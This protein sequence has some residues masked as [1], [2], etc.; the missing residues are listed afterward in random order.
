M[1]NDFSSLNRFMRNPLRIE[2]HLE[3]QI[4]SD[5]LPIINSKPL[6][7][8][9]YILPSQV[10][11]DMSLC[12]CTWNCHLTTGY[13]DVLQMIEISSSKFDIMGI[14]E[15]FLSSDQSLSAFSFPGYD[16][17]VR[18]R[19]TMNRGGLG[20]LIKKNMKYMVREDLGV[21]IEGKIESFCLELEIEKRKVL[22]SVVYR[23]PSARLDEFVAGF[24][25][26]TR[27]V[28][29]TSMDF[30]CMGDF[31][32]NLLDL[33][34]DNLDFF[35]YM[36]SSDLYPLTCVP[37]R[38]STH[39]ATLIDNVFVGPSYLSQSYSDVIVYPGSDHLPVIAHVTCLRKRRIPAKKILTRELKKQNLNSFAEELS[40]IK[41]DSVL[42]ISGDSSLAYNQFMYIFQP[43]YEKTCPLRL[44]KQKRD[45]PRKPWITEAII[46]MIKKRNLLYE[47]YLNSQDD[48]DFAEFK[49]VRNKVNSMRRQAKKKYFE[50][51]FSDSK[52]DT[53]ATW[54]VINEFMGNQ[55]SSQSPCIDINGSYVSDKN[56]V[57]NHFGQFYSQVG[58]S[59]QESVRCDRENFLSEE[60][61]DSRGDTVEFQF[62]KCTSDEVIKIVKN[63]KSNSAGID[64]VNLRTF[65]AVLMYIL[66]CILHI[67]N[68]SMETGT[69][70][71][72][73]KQAKVIPLYKGGARSDA[74]NW[75]P[76]SILPLLSKIL[77]K[78]IH[79]RLYDH[80]TKHSLLS[81]TQFGF[82][83]GHSTSHA[84]I[85]LVDFVNNCLVKGEIPL[86]V[87]FDFR[88]AFDTVDFKIL[89]QRLECLGVKGVSLK[90]FE[91]YLCGR[92]IKVMIDDA[93]SSPYQVSCGV[94]Q[95][96][97]LGPLLYL[98][99]V[100]SMR[101]Y[102]PDCCLTSFADDTA[103][104]FSSRCLDS[105]VL[106]VNCVLR[107]FHVFTS[108]SLL[109]V[110]VTKTNFIVYSRVGKPSDID[111]RILF[112][113]KP[114][115]QV[116]EIRY[117][118]FYIDCNFSWKRHSDVVATKVA[119]GLGAIRR[120]KNFLPQRVLLLLYH[121]LIHPYASY[122]CMLWASN[123][124][125]NFK[126]VQTLQNR[127]M[128]L[129]GGYVEGVN[130]T[131][132]CFNKL[133]VLN[134]GQLR[135]YQIGIF[136][137]QCWNDVSPEVFRDYF[138]DN[139]SLHHYET[140]HA[141]DF[142]V[143]N[144]SGTRAGFHTRFSGPN[145]WNSIPESIRAAEHLGL[146]KN[147]L[148]KYLL[149]QG[150]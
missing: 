116:Q 38:I 112:N 53:K 7:E 121:A 103:V 66:P 58:S 148:K 62:E 34:G 120:F 52:G 70:P 17:E 30:F 72:A 93:F 127:A 123:F 88:K 142:I 115:V 55:K 132:A 51:K 37:T 118:G 23:P 15:T 8:S 73:L 46:D 69:F 130:N 5:D 18:N 138:N 91:S 87:F 124:Y 61:V 36:I 143:P 2:D 95:G 32:Y 97:V 140:R 47:Q 141:S 14:C 43:I 10:S 60:F 108:L 84:A 100:D 101:F 126:R 4:G 29:S 114:V 92:S 134:V 79:R 113:N 110:N 12:L 105:L 149:G 25:E 78:V 48:A 146:F 1:L 131:S 64:G 57:A 86:T 128:R 11:G 28:L 96:S 54:Q 90:W 83:K 67:I 137:Y 150:S 24:D 22:I 65:K 40:C 6:R 13:L 27:L 98:V 76:I 21:W 109:S 122:G 59:V 129:I 133:Q 125:V 45:D 111:G 75:R 77:E 102:L 136:A 26:L 49:R 63:I 3:A 16:F 68:L 144:R 44:T 94:P 39:S 106:K 9:S 71:E 56:V 99:Y 119:R 104:T 41:W 145:V 107:Y 147:K 35:N 135:D 19:S 50:E 31:N 89:L 82:R 42:G 33:S 20:F 117:L 80:L 81:D 74:G 139:R 85:H